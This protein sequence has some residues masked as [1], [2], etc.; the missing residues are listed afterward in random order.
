MLTLHLQNQS[1]KAEVLSVKCCVV[2]FG[3][4]EGG[5]R[6]VFLDVCKNKKHQTTDERTDVTS[7]VTSVLTLGEHTCFY[8]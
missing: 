1:G 2:L 7:T 4:D 3:A 5:G 8:S 6:G